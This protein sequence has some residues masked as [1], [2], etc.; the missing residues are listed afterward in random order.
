MAGRRRA[1]LV[2]ALLAGTLV[3]AT[4]VAVPVVLNEVDQRTVAVMGPPATPDGEPAA[5]LG[6]AGVEVFED[7][8]TE[9]VPG[10]V[11]YEQVPPAGGPHDQIWLECGV[12]DE[13]V[14]DENAVHSLEHGTVWI[15]YDPDLAAA[16]VAKLA[17]VLPDEGILSPYAG[18]TA[19]VT[20]TVWE[21][22]LDLVGADDPRLRLFLDEFGDGNT[23]PEPFAS[24][25]GGVTTLDEESRGRAV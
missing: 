22:Q 20:I 1:P 15:T 4:A 12:Y 24:C 3:L 21:R 25:A 2:I 11:D 6:L 5:L 23:A 16:A 19:P 17:A 9:H 13:P 7:L 8:Q 14:R 18:L 10:N